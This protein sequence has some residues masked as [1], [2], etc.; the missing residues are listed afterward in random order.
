MEAVTSRA[1][2]RSPRG[3]ETPGESASFP[4]ECGESPG[5]PR[6]AAPRGAGLAGCQRLQELLLLDSCG[7]AGS[8]R[9]LLASRGDGGGG[10]AR[11]EAPAP[12]I[13]SRRGNS[14][15]P[16][17]PADNTHGRIAGGSCRGKERRVRCSPRSWQAGEE[18]EPCR[19]LWAPKTRQIRLPRELIREVSLLRARVP[20]ELGFTFTPSRPNGPVWEKALRRGKG[21]KKGKRTLKKRNKGLCLFH[22]LLFPAV[23]FRNYWLHVLGFFKH[24]PPSA[25]SHVSFSPLAGTIPERKG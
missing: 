13:A 24:R 21:R 23:G 20:S 15:Q 22:P 16:A 1:G 25:D 5:P 12:G 11:R 9:L 10:R 7:L 14:G 6:A 17:C 3:C 18:R 8:W 4:L 19:V 2:S